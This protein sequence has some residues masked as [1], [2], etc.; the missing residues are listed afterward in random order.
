M[1]ANLPN[2][3]PAITPPKQVSR[4]VFALLALVSLAA[5]V[6][7]WFW[8][9]YT[10]EETL[11]LGAG[12]ELR[13]KDGLTDI[14]CDEAQKRHLNI[15]VQ[16][17][18]QPGEAIQKVSKHELDAAIIPA[19]LSMKA[20]YVRQ[21]TM[22]DPQ[23]LHLFAK[24]EVAA[25]GLAGLRTRV[26]YLGQAG[27]GVHS[28]AAEILTFAGLTA[29]RDFVEDPRG[30]EA[31]LKSPPDAMPDAVFSLSPL[32]S[33]MGE[34]L[35]RQ[36]GYQLMELPMGEALALRK[37]SFEDAVIPA[38]TYGAAPAAPARPLH[39]VGVR[40]MLIAHRDVSALA[41]E[42]LLEVLFQSDFSRRANLKKMDPALIQRGSDLRF[43][44]GARAYMHRAD[45]WGLKELMPKVQ[46]FIGST[47]S[48]LSAI[49]LAWQWI[50]RKKVNVGE[51][52]Q[53]C[54]NLDL[55]A[56]RAACQGQF[57]EAELG[58][59]LTQLAKLKAEVLERHH[60][61]YM[62]ADKAIV[63]VVARIEELQHVLPGLVR[64]RVSPKRFQLDFGPP[65]RKA[66]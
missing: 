44:L 59:C 48:A 21:V 45:P 50:R 23:V 26:V 5:A 18:H 61:Q 10:N 25:Q 1:M 31:M 57:G 3:L 51:Y 30:Y 16:W 42:R 4:H 14:L 47:L 19:G 53:Q 28:V 46:G 37:T 60:L 54:T 66:A 7:L 58:N 20:D 62:R 39:T 2:P 32:P 63:N 40:G 29:G 24:P 56:Q 17:T 55:D 11:K 12:M 64:T 13:Y 34:K 35:V 52:Q 6:G 9:N 41:V 65:P 33:P 27:S 38:D 36:Y 43:H 22:M 8:F 15:E 49:L